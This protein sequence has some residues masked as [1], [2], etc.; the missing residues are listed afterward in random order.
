LVE[1]IRFIVSGLRNAHQLMSAKINDC[2]VY[3]QINGTL[4]AFKSG[5][6][7][8]ARFCV[9]LRKESKYLEII[10]RSNRL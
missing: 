9:L 2:R 4:F 5:M 3:P 6:L 1:S 7:P 10:F 8:L